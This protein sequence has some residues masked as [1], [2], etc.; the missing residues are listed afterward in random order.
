MRSE[1]LGQA[2]AVYAERPLPSVEFLA[3]PVLIWLPLLI[4]F[5]L[6]RSA[7]S[8]VIL[9][10]VSFF[11]AAALFCALDTQYRVSPTD[12][13]LHSGF[14]HGR[15]LFTSILSV[16]RVK[17][18]AIHCGWLPGYRGFCN[19]F[20]DALV[21]KTRDMSIYFTPKDCERFAALLE[22]RLEARGA[23]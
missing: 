6:H 23:C 5:F 4:I 3:S 2:T 14:V 17:F 7:P 13:A 18:P 16:K 19:R 12:V 8:G 11:C 15:I 20:T 21:L 22:E 10:V 1:R 9:I